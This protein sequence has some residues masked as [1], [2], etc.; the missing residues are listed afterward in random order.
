MFS[1]DQLEYAMHQVMMAL[2]IIPDFAAWYAI[3]DELI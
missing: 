1:T 2:G 3:G